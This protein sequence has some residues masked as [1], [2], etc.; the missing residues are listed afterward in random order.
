L[1]RGNELETDEDDIESLRYE[2]T[3]FRN[4]K[5]L[6]EAKNQAMKHRLLGKDAAL[7]KAKIWFDDTE[8]GTGSK[9]DNLREMLHKALEL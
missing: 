8:T 9:V 6:L 4:K 2:L 7:L 5:V 3:E 1:K